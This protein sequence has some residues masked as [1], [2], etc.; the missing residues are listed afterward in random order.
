MSL[1]NIFLALFLS[2][3]SLQLGLSM[4]LTF[5]TLV[6]SALSVLAG[7]KVFPVERPTWGL[8]LVLFATGALVGSQLLEE[9]AREGSWIESSSLFA[10]LL[11]SMLIYLIWRFAARVTPA[12]QSPLDRDAQYILT[13]GLLLLLLMS[14]P[15]ETIVIL[16]STP[17]A[18]IAISGILLTC[19]VLIADHCRGFLVSRL[20]LLAP[21]VL[22]VPAMLFLLE[23]AQG[24]VVAAMGNLLPR[25]DGFTNTGFSL[26][27][28]LDASAFLRPSTRSVM[29]LNTTAL[30]NRYLAGN[31]LVRLDEEMV[32]QPSEVD[33][34]FLTTFDADSLESGEWRYEID[35]HHVSGRGEESTS[36]N[37]HSLN[38]DN[39]IFLNPGT[40]HVSGDFTA[41]SK[42]SADVWTPSF[43]R[44]SNRRWQLE[45]GGSS[46]PEPDNAENL[47]LPDFWDQTLQD[48][49]QGFLGEGQSQTVD[50]VLDHFLGRAYSLQTN[51]DAE[52]L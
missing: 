38:R 19:L 43:D 28:R 48:K 50:N 8:V 26:N 24:P 9:I 12:A 10:G 22:L 18:L 46:T 20:L 11:L 7:F 49:S 32:W 17:V 33:R 35:N 51:F 14:P 21:V 31:R 3:L 15:P 23:N 44:G 40:S 16:F 36:I 4:E 13:M 25:S 30:P 1:S 37:I 34:Q 6:G 5:V 29:R 41:L 52:K 45:V 27:Q 42:N 39:Y 47:Q 2:L